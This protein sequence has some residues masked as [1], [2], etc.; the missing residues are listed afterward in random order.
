M[1]WQSGDVSVHAAISTLLVQRCWANV[2]RMSHIES[3]LG[4][5]LNKQNCSSRGGT[6]Y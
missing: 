3:L 6:R 5:G 1:A 4:E 2:H